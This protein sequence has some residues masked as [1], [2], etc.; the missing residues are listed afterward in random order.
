[1]TYFIIC[2]KLY[3][4][5]YW[6]NI[7][8]WQYQRRNSTRNTHSVST[9]FSCTPLVPFCRLL[10]WNSLWH[11][12]HSEFCFSSVIRRINN[13]DGMMLQ[14][15]FNGLFSLCCTPN[16]ENQPASRGL[17]KN[18]EISR[19]F[20]VEKYTSLSL[21]TSGIWAQNRKYVYE[22]TL[23]RAREIFTHLRLS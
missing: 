12:Q 10:W 21:Q 5:S 13:T 22:V 15:K 6:F 3:K 11:S 14:R 8:R 16:I 17:T 7:F 2:L 18:T 4:F 20:C 1:M 23:R 9:F 19:S